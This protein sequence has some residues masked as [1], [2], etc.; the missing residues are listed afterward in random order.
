M[1]GRQTSNEMAA[2]SARIEGAEQ[3][4]R[5][6]LAAT[7]AGRPRADKRTVN[8]AVGEAL[9]QLEDARAILDSLQ[10]SQRRKVER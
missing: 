9:R 5:V 10:R 3:A 6:A 8:A 7:E 4:L 2:A 1:K